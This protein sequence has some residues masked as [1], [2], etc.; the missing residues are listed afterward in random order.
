MLDQSPELLHRIRLL[1]QTP[2]A[3]AAALLSSRFPAQTAVC[4]ALQAEA[5]SWW[6][7]PGI[8]ALQ[9][10][11]APNYFNAYD[12]RVEKL[13][14]LRLPSRAEFHCRRL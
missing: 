14:D 13:S 7:S 6:G 1:I 3:C 8:I 9:A 5:L 2:C 4:F 12:Y 10:A 11:A